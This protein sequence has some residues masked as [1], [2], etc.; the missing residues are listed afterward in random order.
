VCCGP[1][2]ATSVSRAG[3]GNEPEITSAR[4]GLSSATALWQRSDEGSTQDHLCGFLHLCGGGAC[5]PSL[6]RSTITC[7]VRRRIVSEYDGLERSGCCAKDFCSIGGPGGR[8]PR[9]AR[10]LD[11]EGLLNWK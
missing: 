3:R 8:H 9:C 1:L 11:Q 2:W 5:P 4:L 6:T 10:D 7:L